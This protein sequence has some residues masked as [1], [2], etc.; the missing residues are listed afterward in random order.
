MI[1]DLTREDRKREESYSYVA[2][3]SLLLYII[4]SLE[5]EKQY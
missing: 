5:M 3:L 1:K 2:D 4:L